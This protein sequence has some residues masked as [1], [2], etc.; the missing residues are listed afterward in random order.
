[1]NSFFEIWN[2][3]AHS[4]V[5]N[6]VLM[7]ALLAWLMG[8]FNF[9]SLLESVK[10]EIIEA[11]EKSKKEKS[12]AKKELKS[13]QTSSANLNSE[14]KSL[15][16]DAKTRAENLSKK[17]MEETEAKVEQIKSGIQKAAAAEEKVI[18]SRLSGKAAQES[19]NL[20]K[21]DIIG[22]LKENPG[23]HEQFINESIENI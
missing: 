3:L 16:K 21:N 7:I 1:M 6:V 2:Y 9:A 10:N 12:M 5:F 23:L 4:N 11:I 20:A 13:A 17:I 19:V 8:K 22:K 15:L 18:S 14:V